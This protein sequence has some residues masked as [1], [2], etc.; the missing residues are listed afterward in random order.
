M[1]HIAVLG[2]GITGVTTAYLL[3]QAGHDVTVVERRAYAAMETSY[4][5]GGQLSASNAEVWNQPA[6]L[7]KGLRWMFQPDAPLLLNPRPSWHKYSWLAE[8]LWAIRKY[9]DNTVLT[10]QL[11]IEAR[12]H[13][14]AMAE[15]ERVDFDLEKRGILHF[16]HDRKSFEA[17]RKSNAL[18]QQG[19]LER[20][21]VTADEIRQIEPSLTGQYFG[22]FY[23]QSDAT[24][25]IHK[26]TRGLAQA[27]ERKG[28]RFLYGREVEGLDFAQ[29]GVRIDMSAPES[30]GKDRE[31]LQADAIVICG[32]VGSRGLAALAGDRV[33]V[34]PVKG[35]SITVHLDDEASVQGAPWTSLLDEKAKIVTSRLG[36]DR[37]RVAGTAEFNGENRDIRA[38]RIEPLVR[39][40]RANFSMNTSRVVPWAGLRPMM[41][42]MMPRVRRGRRDGVYY[43][44]GHGHLGWTL[45]GVTAARVADL[46]QADMRH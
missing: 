44:T 4:A 20:H 25:D 43:N 14:F 12:R 1:A 46:I 38:D 27:T 6:T 15:Q 29:G 2:A 40:T 42:D 17:A 18:L 21:E 24:G 22:G 45:S 37:F 33:N 41:P 32:G 30:G 16:Y 26:F 11:A 3:N 13:L 34:Y 35:Y 8:F 19:G 39:W 9:R 7:L 5:N 31:S 23:T 36:R 10:T 28:A